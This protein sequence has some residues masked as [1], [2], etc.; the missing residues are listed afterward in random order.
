MLSSLRRGTGADV[1]RPR[2]PTRTKGKLGALD[3][4]KAERMAARYGPVVTA[5]DFG[6]GRL[7]E[8]GLVALPG[9]GRQNRDAANLQLGRIIAH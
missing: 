9:L 5:R 4:R 1:W 2:K 6:Q 7:S 3:G 8:I